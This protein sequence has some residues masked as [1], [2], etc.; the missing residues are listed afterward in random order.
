MVWLGDADFVGKVEGRMTEDYIEVVEGSK[1]IVVVD[2]MVM[3]KG[4]MVVV[5]GKGDYIVE[6]DNY[7]NLGSYLSLVVT[8]LRDFDTFLAN[9]LDSLEVD[10][11]ELRKPRL[12]LH[13]SLPPC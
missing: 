5:E 11:L 12:V 2:N 3:E 13:M 7:D 8:S 1:D 10:T 6:G 9:P 4:S